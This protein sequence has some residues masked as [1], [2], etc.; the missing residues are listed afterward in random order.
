M[1]WWLWV[2]LGVVLAAIELATPGGLVLIFFAVGAL[3]VGALALLDVVTA[4]WAQWLL[5]P[6][7]ALVTLRLF[8]Q[9]LMGRLRTGDEADRVD[10]LVG[11]LAMPSADIPPGGHG[12]AELRGSTW[13][14]RNVTAVPLSTGQRCRVVGVQGLMLD[15]R[16]EAN[17]E[18]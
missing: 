5:F 7:V 11:E 3:A 4:T 15:I 2:A 13:N 12:R 18:S 9:P 14:V 6:I 10:T 16:A 1:S 8:R 17:R